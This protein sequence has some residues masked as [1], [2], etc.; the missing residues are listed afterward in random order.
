MN[1][2]WED[3]K[4]L[5][6]GAFGYVKLLK[7]V[8]TEELMAL[9]ELIFWRKH[10]ET[11]FMY[12]EYASGGSLGDLKSPLAEE[13]AL[14]YFEQIRKGVDFMHSRGVIHRDLKPDNILLTEDRVVKI[15][16]LG[17]CS[18]YIWKGVEIYLSGFSGT[19]S[20]MAPEV[21][22]SKKY[23]GPPID[24]WAC[25]IILF[26]M[27]TAGHPWRIA[28]SNERNY[29]LWMQRKKKLFRKKFWNTLEGSSSWSLLKRMLAVDPE[30]RISGWCQL[31]HEEKPHQN[32]N[33]E[34]VKYLGVGAFGY[35]K[36]LKNVETEELMALKEVRCKSTSSKE[37]YEA[38]IHSQLNHENIIQLFFWR[39][40]Y[41]TLFM[42]LEYASGGS[43][44]D[45]KRPL[46]EEDALCYFEQIRKGVDF[47]HSRGV[48]HRDLKPDNILLTEDRVVK[49]ADLGLCSVYIWKGVEIYL[50]GF[51]GTLSYMA[52][53]V[54]T[55]KKY[56][57]PP[58][59]V[60]ACGIILFNMLTAGHPWRIADPD[61][62]NYS[63]WMQRKKKLFRKRFWDTLEG[64]SSWS[65]LKCL[66]AVDPERRISG[67]R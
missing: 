23:R 15:A 11:L 1:K 62:R 54:F 26:N 53:E 19:L 46:A 50:S 61:E 51:S 64:S 57:G 31:R 36:L 34:D 55:G 42:Y 27:L 45:L 30:K 43:L 38:I 24:V 9:K 33:W 39:K 37:L 67:W 63:L 25:G 3:V 22:T 2:N 28:D 40:H 41:E 21:F 10:Y 6:V 66:L 58:I 12:L 20:Y 13:D 29:S 65:L 7:N 59:D 8:E 49:I 14:C 35:V 32:K 44:G 48:I 17:L 18:V 60:W 56:R 4:Y 52:P 5:G 16:D 47:M